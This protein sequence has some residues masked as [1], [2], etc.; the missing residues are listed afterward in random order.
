MSNYPTGYINEN[1][2]HKVAELPLASTIITTSSIQN[3]FFKGKK[4][5][6]LTRKGMLS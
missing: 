4:N 3:W 6:K 1:K 2:N 5:I